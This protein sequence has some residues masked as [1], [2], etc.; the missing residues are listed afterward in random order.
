M[1]RAH[2]QAWC[3]QDEY[4][5]LEL[6]DIRR[7]E[8]E[9]QL[10]LQETMAGANE[11]EENECDNKSSSNNIIDNSDIKKSSPHKHLPNQKSHDQ[12]R[13][14]ENQNRLSPATSRHSIRSRTS[15]RSLTSTKS[16][17]SIGKY[18]YITGKP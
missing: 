8:R 15:H 10:A 6:S 3:W 13:T 14:I 11:T 17:S 9:T 16:K 1:L 5:G 12:V 18:M 2:R 4:Y 7:L